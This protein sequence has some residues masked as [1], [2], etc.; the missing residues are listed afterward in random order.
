ME[1]VGKSDRLI[2]FYKTMRHGGHVL[3]FVGWTNSSMVLG[4][5]RVLSRSILEYGLGNTRVYLW[6]VLGYSTRWAAQT[7]FRILAIIFDSGVG[8][9]SF[10]LGCDHLDENFPKIPY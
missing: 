1:Y 8:L 5:T 6:A 9:R 3:E 4:Y 7:S 10:K 2:G